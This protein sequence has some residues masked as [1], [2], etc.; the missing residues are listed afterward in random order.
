MTAPTP[1]GIGYRELWAADPGAWRLA[2]TAWS[3]TA[4]L[5]QRRGGELAT[6]AAGLRE[7]WSG[8]A[9]G[10][11]DARL[12]GLRTELLAG[13]PGLIEAD[14]VLAEFGGRLA[15]AR[16]RLS[17]AV[18]LADRSGVQVD[19][20]GRVSAGP[21]RPAT[22]GTGRAA[23]EVAAAIGAALDVARAAD[24]E[25][26]G[27]LAEL[28]GAAGAGWAAAPPPGRPRPGATPAAVRSWWAALT[29]AQRRWLVAHEPERI[30][31]L[32]GV[33]VAARD[34]ANRLLLGRHREELLGARRRLLGRV[35]PGPVELVGLRRVEA[36]LAGLDAVTA[37][38]AAPE[39]PRAYLLGLATQ[40]EGRA[41]VALGNPDRSGPVLT[42]VPGMTAGLD[43][44]SGE[45]DRAAR[46]LSRCASRA[47]EEEAAAVLW[48][49]YDA[50]DFL[51]E[52]AWPGQAGDAGRALHR[53]QE[54]LSVTHDGPDARRTVL[55]HSYGSLVVG[56][57]ARDH[58]LAADALV[59][60]G[61]P[62]VGVD[63]ARELGLPPG[64]VWAST[65]PD[66]VIRLARSPEELLRRPLLAA[67]PLGAAV[68]LLDGPDRQLWFGRDPAD[69][70][71]GGHTFPSGRYGH[72]GYW[73]PDNPALDGVARVVLGR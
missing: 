13:R 72:T 24:R 39:G 1:S 35:P 17:A 12:G 5:V 43:D 36:A 61:S 10:T 60:L 19:R 14:Q 50:P 6:G 28:S 20:G 44:V 22:P 2:G 34:Q 26:A 9:A 46:V 53:F 54:G 18:A 58:G 69:P 64:G 49:D 48:L 57:T 47:P 23:A 55:G 67:S 27:R 7:A 33:P 45:L 4:A 73:H 51:H 70:G 41:V 29:P 16:A 71:F 30:G 8:R 11:A 21:A 3:G 66:D 63:H 15:V 56:A 62:G 31:C 25:A 65:A 59:F 32:D 37:R 38:L 40:G 68:A 42:Y 52:A